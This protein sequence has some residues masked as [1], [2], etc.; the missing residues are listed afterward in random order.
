MK[1]F[2]VTMI[3]KHAY[4]AFDCKRYTWY[5]FEEIL[6]TTFEN[7]I[8]NME[9]KIMKMKVFLIEEK[10]LNEQFFIVTIRL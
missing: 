2:T 6:S 9:R 5:E 4:K 3:E 1:R 8:V 10:T 7:K